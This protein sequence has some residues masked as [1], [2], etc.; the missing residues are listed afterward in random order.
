MT[1]RSSKI[2]LIYA[3]LPSAD[4]GAKSSDST[5][6][7]LAMR[8][9]ASGS[10]V[11]NNLRKLKAENRAHILRWTTT[12]PPGPVWVSGPGEDAPRPLPL[13]KEEIRRRHTERQ[14]ARRKEERV[15]PTIGL[16]RQLTYESIERARHRPQSWCSAL[17]G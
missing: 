12:N 15:D 13:S 4:V 9:R 3:A 7:A 6:D 14:R 2:E 11:R 8:T 17:M 1:T 10:N 5:P 16:A